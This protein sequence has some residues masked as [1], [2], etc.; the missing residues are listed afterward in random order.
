[1]S[2]TLAHD[3]VPY[4]EENS[5]DYSSKAA[6]HFELVTHAGRYLVAS[7]PCPRC[8]AHLDIPL[9]K[10]AVRG[11]GNAGPAAAPTEIP[12]CCACDGDHP[13]RPD[14]GEGCGAYWLLGIPADLT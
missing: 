14:G 3:P 6:T 1:M 8:N 13:G 7:G 12:M 9:L 2:T 11:F 10:E 5:E 4:T